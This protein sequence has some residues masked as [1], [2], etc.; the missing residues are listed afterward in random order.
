[1]TKQISANNRIILFFL[2]LIVVLG[3]MDFLLIVF[4]SSISC[5]WLDLFFLPKDF[6]QIWKAEK[7]LIQ[8]CSSLTEVF[9]GFILSENYGNLYEEMTKLHYAG[10]MEEF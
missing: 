8:I 7:L 2:F 10:S 4:M 6:Y 5:F 9:Q 3:F 1:M